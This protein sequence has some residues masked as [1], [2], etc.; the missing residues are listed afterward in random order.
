M[1]TQH[2]FDNQ[3][4]SADCREPKLNISR[5]DDYVSILE[6]ITENTEQLSDES[7]S[8]CCHVSFKVNSCKWKRNAKTF[9]GAIY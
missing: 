4:G 9:V 1:A 7:Q 8:Q 2:I 6:H 3:A 5:H